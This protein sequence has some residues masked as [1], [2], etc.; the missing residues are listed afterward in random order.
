MKKGFSL[1]E[2]I[3]VIVVLGLVSSMAVNVI[4]TIYG[5]YLDTKSIDTISKKSEFALEQ[6]KARLEKRVRTPG[7]TI[8]RDSSGTPY[9]LS[10]APSDEYRIIEW[11][12]IDMDT[13]YGEY[14]IATNRNLPGWTGFV[15]IDNINTNKNQIIT[16]GSRLD[17]AN[18]ILLSK[19]QGEISL[20]NDSDYSKHPVIIFKTLPKNTKA[21]EGF[22]WDGTTTTK[23]VHRVH[24]KN[25]NCVANPDILTFT[26]P[27]SLG[28]EIYE[29]YDFVTT[30]YALVFD[31]DKKYVYLY[32]NY[33]PWN[34]EKYT[35]GE[36]A[37][38]ISGVNDFIISTK[39]TQTDINDNLSHLLRVV[40]TVEDNATSDGDSYKMKKEILVD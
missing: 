38:L 8:V 2:L 21:V 13:Y 36:R 9:P 29:R 37:L 30:A 5:S 27:L 7:A 31:K 24:C 4:M 6:I 12:G 3:F 40:L 10:D 19:Y 14:D 35:D 15:D 33:R 22:G 23:R 20:E 16:P 17:F 11:L 1:L 26:N 32:Y 34:N 18:D 28:T 39:S 25:Y